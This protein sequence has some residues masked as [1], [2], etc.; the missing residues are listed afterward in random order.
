V[1]SSF[2]PQVSTALDEVVVTV[3]RE[4]LVGACRALKED[5]RL[6]FDFLRCLSVVDYRDRFEVVCHLWSM[7][8][9]HKAVVKTTAPHDDPRVPSLTSVWRATDWF[10]REGHDLY[11]VVFDGHPNLKP[12][13]LWEGFEGYPG[14]KDYPFY[15]YKEW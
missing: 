6:A 2:S 10:E 4:H 7:E 11:G 13:L 5:P 9:R 15:D 14:R 3:G 1:L 12:L 8:R